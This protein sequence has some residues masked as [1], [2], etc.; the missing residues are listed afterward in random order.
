MKF[1]NIFPI[2]ILAAV[3]LGAYKLSA[4]GAG[5]GGCPVGL[6][7]SYL[8]GGPKAEKI[9]NQTGQHQPAP[10]WELTDVNGKIVKLSDFRGKVVVL[11][12]WAT[13]CPPC[14]EEIPGFISLQNEYGEKG[15][16]I[17]GVSLDNG[18]V[19]AVN[20]FFT[21]M[22]INY[23]VMIGNKLVAQRYGGITMLPSTFIIDRQGNITA[24]HQG[25]LDRATLESEIKGLL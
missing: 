9:S 8:Y 3:S 4:N 12:F 25:E 18:G 7:L 21:R 20:P 14:R 16:V 24:A 11:N 1:E 15:L 2:I 22:G 10:D 6:A 13:W 23:P 19:K 5:C 17:V